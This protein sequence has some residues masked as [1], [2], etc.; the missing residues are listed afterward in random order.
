MPILGSLIRKAYELRQ[1]P[2]DIRF[3]DP[4][5]EQRRVLSRLMNSAR[6]TAFGETY[7]FGKI[8]GSRDFIEE[9][10]LQVPVHDYS[11]MFKNWWY[12]SL[13][14]EAF[15]TWPGRVKYFALTSG[16]SE[17]SS[18]H[19]PVTSDMLRAIQRASVRQL[20]STTKYDFPDE[21]Y[22]KGILMIGGS[23]H[24]QYN[25]TYYQGDL[26]GIT[27]KNI[28][29]WFQH[30]YKPGRRISRE[31][32]W[33]V[34]LNEI[35]RNARSW[36]IGIIVGVPAWIQIMMEKI[37]DFYNVKTIHDIWPNLAAYVH[38][39][40]SFEPY[41]RSFEN[42]L[43]KPIL[44]N[45][46][47]LASEGYIAYQRPGN[48]KSM[49][50]ILDNGIFFEFIPFNESN[51]DGEGGLKPNPETLT[52]SEVEEGKEYALLLST[53]AGAWRYLIGDTIKFISREKCEIALTG[54]TKQFISLCGEHLSQDNL[55]R[56]IGMLQEE[57]H[58]KISEFTITGIRCGNLFAHHWYLGTN[59]QLDPVLA[60]RK[61]DE[62]LKVLNDD[63]R[64]ERIEAIKEVTA[65]VLPLQA[66]LDWM[67]ISGKE[68]G[69]HKFPRVLKT[70]QREQW[71]SFISSIKNSI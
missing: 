11:S 69:A 33:S 55:N 26:S 39:G 7:N 40:V 37:I 65:E 54:R 57:L 47:Y 61:L 42:L 29:F 49:E 41:I 18:K 12:R 16:T 60:A 63:Y 10:R 38:S 64:V 31:Q 1:F 5:V 14:G 23:T 45:E 53:C 59:N 48:L 51:F 9:F 62:Y 50:M 46:S 68:G 35:I 13:N 15:V 67:K 22:E 66:F 3:I 27:A 17:T 58:V 8:I 52:I 70:S 36:D 56:A 71:E 19:I 43:Q 4:A 30:F 6:N 32:E 21:F 44:Y 20:V 34:K 28:P 24:L 25:G 2:I